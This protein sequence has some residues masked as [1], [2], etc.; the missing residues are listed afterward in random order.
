MNEHTLRY[1]LSTM[2]HQFLGEPKIKDFPIDP[3][4]YPYSYKYGLLQYD[5]NYY[6][7]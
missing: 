5:N 2:V 1:F 4:Y 6:F 7:I 3:Y